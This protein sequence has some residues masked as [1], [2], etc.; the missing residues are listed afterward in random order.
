MEPARFLL[1]QGFPADPISVQRF[2]KRVEYVPLRVFRPDLA[3]VSTPDWML[4]IA[5]AQAGFAGL[6]TGDKSQLT[7]DAE[8]IALALTKLTLVTWR[9]G[10]ED[11]I[12]RWGQLLTYMPQI[13]RRMEPNRA[14]VM[15]IPNPRLSQDSVE[16]PSDLARA[17]Q[18]HD[19]VSF[20]ERRGQQLALMRPALVARGFHDWLAWL[21][22]AANPQTRE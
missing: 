12:T 7:Q 3:E 17:R 4:Y 13:L 11:P 16:R 14:L 2:D 9:G 6:V 20:P 19:N 10:D 8:L 15:S 22:E 1:D 5:A 21:N 18:Q